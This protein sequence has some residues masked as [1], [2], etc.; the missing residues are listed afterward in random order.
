MFLLVSFEYKSAAVAEA[1]LN[2]LSLNASPAYLQT[3]P[4]ISANRRSALV[5]FGLEICWTDIQRYTA[6][7]PLFKDG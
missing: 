4:C 2:E 6:A 5:R 7:G 3:K 1:A